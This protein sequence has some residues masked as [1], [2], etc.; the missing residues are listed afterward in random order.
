MSAE[1][2]PDPVTPVS[3]LPVSGSGAGAVTVE[4]PGLAEAAVKIIEAAGRIDGQGWCPATSSNFSCRL[5][6]AHCALTVSGRHKGRLTPADILAVDLEGRSLDARRPSAETLLHTSLYR[7]DGRIGA[8]LH[9]H[10]LHATLVS[11]RAGPALVL[12]GLELLKAFRGIET[13]DCRVE[14]PVYDNNQD[15]AALARRI[16]SDW[17]EDMPA[18]PAY[19]IRGHG[20]YVWGESMDDAMRHLE[21]MEFLLEYTWQSMDRGHTDSERGN[22]A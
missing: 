15:I 19:L 4:T 17:R 14:I 7:R 6:A 21:A 20:L 22:R 3:P 13:H 1:P 2:H 9:T 11:M 8:V 16:E 5:D 18:V 12:E 10:S